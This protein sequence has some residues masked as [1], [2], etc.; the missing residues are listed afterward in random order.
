MNH[1]K[2]TWR[3]LKALHQLYK[4]K[5]SD[6]KILDNGY[7]DNVLMKQR[8]L[9]RFKGNN[10]NVLI[11]NPS[12]ALFYE[13][14]FL[15][16]FQ[17][18]EAFLVAQNLETDARRRYTEEDIRTLMFIADQ[19]KELL[20]KLSTIRTFSS[21]LFTGQGSKYLEN[22]QGLKEA[23]LRILG[24]SDFPA[25]DPKDFQWRFVVDCL[26]PSVIVLCEN[27]AHL[28]NAPKA[29][30]NNIELWH[31]GGNNISII[32][33]I[34]PQK[35]A[36]PAFYS[37]DWDFDGLAI[38]GRIKEKLKL[39]QCDIALLEPYTLATALPVNSP[40]H[41]SKWNPNALLSGLKTEY[42]SVT[43]K[44]IIQKLIQEDKW[45]EE[46]SLDLVQLLEKHLNN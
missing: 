4:D 8:R 33:H 19:K 31:V 37:C 42:F 28:K 15:Q 22:R 30:R 21:Q 13:T 39:R 24:I 14:N 41:N 34:S 29:R 44:T 45:I 9:I 38:F 10:I 32:D 3:H 2:L 11:A 46:E 18:Y 6:A 7:I 16:D 40:Y 20:S 1:R 36:L 25:S 26:T 23:V 5:R 12:Y 43:N 27:I 17:T 35:L